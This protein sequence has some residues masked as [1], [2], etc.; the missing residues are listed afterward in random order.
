[1]ERI[2]EITERTRRCVCKYCGSPLEIRNLHFGT[3]ETARSEIFCTSCNR[4]EFGVEPEIYSCAKYFVNEL[5]FNCYPDLEKSEQTLRLN[6]ARICEIIF[7]FCQST[8]IL[9][10]YGFVPE[11]KDIMKNKTNMLLPNELI[12]E[13]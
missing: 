5:D 1:M 10:P 6:V 2:E 11:V 8:E 9:Q 7:W 4:I 12:E 13:C 3:I